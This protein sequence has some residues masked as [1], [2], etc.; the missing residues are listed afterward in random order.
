[1]TKFLKNLYRLFLIRTPFFIISSYIKNFIPNYKTKQKCKKIELKMYRNFKSIN[2]SE[3][4]FCNNLNYLSNNF[5]NKANVNHILEIGSYEGR[6]A[7][8]FLQFFSNSKITCV[9]TWSGSDEHLNYNFNIIEENFDKNTLSFKNNLT[10]Y[11]MTS[12]NFFQNNSKIFDL[13]F[14]DGDHFYDQVLRDINNA[15][16][17]LKNGGFL[18]LDDYLWWYYKDLNKNPANT[19]NSFIMNNYSNISEFKIWHQVILR[20]KS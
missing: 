19:I 9:D 18:I 10:K 20:K 4:W 13:I 1:M 11:K 8:F 17:V 3:K 7:L 6:S 2:E 14:I 15:W 16:K 12:D 5:K